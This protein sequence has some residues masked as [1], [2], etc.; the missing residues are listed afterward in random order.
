VQRPSDNCFTIVSQLDISVINQQLV[1][2]ATV[3]VA[4]VAIVAIIAIIAAN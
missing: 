2:I 3:I 1:A 4:I